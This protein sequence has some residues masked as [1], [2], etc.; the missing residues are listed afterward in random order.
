MYIVNYVNRHLTSV[1]LYVVQEVWQ[2]MAVVPRLGTVKEIGN[3]IDDKETPNDKKKWF[4][5][6]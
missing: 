5:F 6:H 3:I 1:F 2:R 4:E